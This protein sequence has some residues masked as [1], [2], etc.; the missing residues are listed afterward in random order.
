[1]NYK[2]ARSLLYIP[3]KRCYDIAKIAHINNNVYYCVNDVL[4]SGRY[5]KDSK[6]IWNGKQ[7]DEYNRNLNRFK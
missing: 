5:Y 2:I 4:N 7:Y 6:Y 1:M 3:A